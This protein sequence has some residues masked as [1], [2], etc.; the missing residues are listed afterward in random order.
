[1]GNA[2]WALN[3]SPEAVEQFRQA[4]ILKP[5]DIQTI[6]RL[7][8]ALRDIGNF[9]LA[10]TC[11]EKVIELDPGRA[12]GHLGRGRE[13][14]IEGE[15]SSALACFEKAVELDGANHDAHNELGNSLFL[16]D[17]Y[18]EGMAHLEQALARA[19]DE[20]ICLRRCR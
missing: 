5:D 6:C 3:R 2:L 12:E 14:Q 10:R 18:E 7:G 16:W 11:W 13:L 8:H 20:R 9:K 4:I 1:M 15:H 17:R 19:P